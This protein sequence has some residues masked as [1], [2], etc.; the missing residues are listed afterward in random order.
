MTDG[1]VVTSK[2]LPPQISKG[3]DDRTATAAPS[4]TQNLNETVKNVERQLIL[5]ALERC[6]GVQRKAAKL[7]GVTE[8]VLWYKVKKYGIKVTEDLSSAPTDS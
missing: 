3:V 2:Y 8:R 7:L 5:D 1:E 6:D 4:T